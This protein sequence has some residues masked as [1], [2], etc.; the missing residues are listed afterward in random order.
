MKKLFKVKTMVFESGL[1]TGGYTIVVAKSKK[2]A[3][4]KVEKSEE[5]NLYDREI[6]YSIANGSIK[7]HRVERKYNDYINT[8]N[9]IGEL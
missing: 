6:Q 1:P 5:N 3:L 9:Y 2:E 8:V 4:E 7:D